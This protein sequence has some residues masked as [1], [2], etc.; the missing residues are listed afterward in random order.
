MTARFEASNAEEADKA[1]ARFNSFHDDYVAGIEIKF[2]NYK[3]LDEEGASTGIGDADKTVILT[4]NTYPYGTEH[5][6]FVSVEFKDVQSL[7]ISSL[8]GGGPMWG[9]TTTRLASTDDELIEWEFYP[10]CSGARF[11]VICSKIVIIG[12]PFR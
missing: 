2:E 3:G 11:S 5:E 10:I 9:I 12:Q 7:E 1:V 8:P 4:I 6:R